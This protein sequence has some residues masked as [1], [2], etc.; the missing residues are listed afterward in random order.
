MNSPF[1]YPDTNSSRAEIDYLNRKFKNQVIAIIGL[2]GTGS[3]ILDL[4][5]KTPVKQIDLYDYDT[6]ETHNAFRAPGAPCE[7]HFEHHQRLKKVE[8]FGQLYSN[9]H[10]NILAH[11]MLISSENVSSLKSAD[12]IFICVDKSDTRQMICDEL[13]K[14]GKA[15]IDCGLGVTKNDDQLLGTLRVTFADESNLSHLEGR[16]GKESVE[17]NEYSTNIQIA[18]L[19]AL[20][21]VMAVIKWKKTIG[22]YQDLKNES[23]SLF[24]LNTNKLL[25]EDF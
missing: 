2:G 12:M 11:D 19:N 4:V 14:L 10:E 5:A 21:A 15:F 8:Y 17:E 18:D 7:D 22:F 16:I 23:N 25:N 6:F 3:Y 13:L 9:M 24:F 1:K 20:N